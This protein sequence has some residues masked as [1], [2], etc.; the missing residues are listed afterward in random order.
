[1]AADSKATG[2][3]AAA[4]VD[5]AAGE[6]AVD[7]MKSHVAR[8][9]RPE[10]VTDASGFAG[11]FR[12]DTAKYEDP[13]LATSTDGVGTKVL[14]AQK[15]DRH[16]TIGIDLVGMVVD[17]L[18][19][20]G[21]EPLFMTDYI[22]CGAVVP[23]RIAEIVG[24]IAEG[25]HQAGCSLIG[26]ETAEHPGAMGPEEYDLAGAGTGVVEGDAILGPDRV[27]EGDA[28]IAMASSGPHSNGYSLVRHIVDTADLDLTAHVPE[29]GGEL[30]EVLLTPTRIYA[31]D[32]VALTDAV[33]VHAYSHITGGGLAANLSRSLPDHVDADL[34]RSTWTPDPVFGFLAEK[35][36]VSREDM[37][38]TFNMGVGM[39]A[40]VAA[41]SAERA[42]EVLAERGV[43]AWRLGTVRSG[44]GRA[45]LNGD[46]P[47]V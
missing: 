32:C 22:A 28:V 6:R 7:L 41:E 23:E 11:L 13:V 14:L 43:P 3:Y 8:T 20:S 42:L 4:G 31:K 29:L 30:G 36:S 39:V 26:G 40:I 24:G 1:M 2:A 9:R 19:V 5:I 37:E 10:Q 17:D 27:R 47:G 15:L 25:C 45:H 38:A 44:S 33:E 18:V 34:D 12:L 21:A 35:G 46:H 16:D